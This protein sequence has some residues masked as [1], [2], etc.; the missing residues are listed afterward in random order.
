MMNRMSSQIPMTAY[1]DQVCRERQL[2]H[3]QLND[4]ITHAVLTGLRDMNCDASYEVEFDT[5][6]G[7]LKIIEVFDVVD[8]ISSK[9]HITLSEADCLI[10][11][12][13]SAI[14]S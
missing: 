10:R 1:I 3:D 14:R 11:Q 5:A 6:H 12:S 4:V 9:N 7:S 8:E 13:I 2:T